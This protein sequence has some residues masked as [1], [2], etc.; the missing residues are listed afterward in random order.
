VRRCRR[1]NLLGYNARLRR[2][3]RVV[4]CTGLE[5]RRRGNPSV[6]SNLTASARSRYQNPVN[7]IIYWVFVLS[8]PSISPPS[9]TNSLPFRSAGVRVRSLIPREVQWTRRSHSPL[10][11]FGVQPRLRRVDARAVCGGLARSGS[12]HFQTC[13]ISPHS[14]LLDDR[15]WVCV[16]AWTT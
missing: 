5:N 2:C 8:G 11:R 14:D 13:L 10:Q 1:A 7:S 6:S 12:L 15:L 3:G 9:S 4:E 16:S